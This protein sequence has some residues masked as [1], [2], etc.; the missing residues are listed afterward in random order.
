MTEALKAYA[1][2]VVV[3]VLALAVGLYLGARR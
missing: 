2:V 3:L 1:T